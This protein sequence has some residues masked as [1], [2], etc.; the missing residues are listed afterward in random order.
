MRRCLNIMQA[1]HMAY[2]IVD[3]TNV[4]ICTGNATPEEVRGALG[5]LLNMNFLDSFRCKHLFPYE[6]L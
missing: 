3:E 1:T 2:P 5:A 6:F 4:Y